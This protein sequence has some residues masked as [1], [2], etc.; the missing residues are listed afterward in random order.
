VT[1]NNQTS[2]TVREFLPFPPKI[3]YLKI[4][5]NYLR[6]EIKGKGYH[7]GQTILMTSITNCGAEHCSRDH[8]L[9]G[10]S[11]LSQHYM[12]PEGSILSSQDLS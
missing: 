11:I 3:L 6:R 12:E 10:H 4:P 7:V 2:D 9:L 1:G 5:V 8:Q